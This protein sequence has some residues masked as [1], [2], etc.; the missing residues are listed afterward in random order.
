MELYGSTVF[1]FCRRLYRIFAQLGDN[2]LLARCPSVTG[3]T[4]TICAHTV[5]CD[6]HNYVP[7][8]VV[9]RA[10][11]SATGRV[12]NDI[13]MTYS[14]TRVCV[15]VCGHFCGYKCVCLRM[16]ESDRVTHAGMQ[17]HGK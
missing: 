2:V 16:C 8:N 9:A 11:L 13:L 15:C 14:R 17:S 7:A 5:I 6:V 10:K 4:H 1:F 3:I 12:A